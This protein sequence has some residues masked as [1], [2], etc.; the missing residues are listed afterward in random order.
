MEGRGE[1]ETLVPTVTAGR[2][3]DRT[4][5]YEMDRVRAE[6]ADQRAQTRAT[7]EREAHIRI[8]GAGPGAELPRSDNLYAMTAS[9]QRTVQCGNCRDNSV[10][11]WMPRIGHQGDA[12]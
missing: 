4:F 11:L 9:C 12:Q 3:T 8:S 6:L 5:G 7:Q 10:D 1:G 2:V